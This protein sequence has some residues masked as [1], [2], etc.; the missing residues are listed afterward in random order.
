MGECVIRRG[1]RSGGDS[2]PPHVLVSRCLDVDSNFGV[3]WRGVF[4]KEVS[5]DIQSPRMALLAAD[6]F[7]DCSS[8][9][10]DTQS[11]LF[12]VFRLSTSGFGLCQMRREQVCSTCSV[13]NH[14]RVT[15][16]RCYYCRYY[17]GG[18]AVLDKPCGRQPQPVV[19]NMTVAGGSSMSNGINLAA[20]YTNGCQGY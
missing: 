16:L 7:Y 19:A 9:G 5:F 15:T 12:E 18:L 8:S 1:T 6:C 14:R 20:V 3:A 17:P 13:D 11:Q 4:S 2:A 10:R